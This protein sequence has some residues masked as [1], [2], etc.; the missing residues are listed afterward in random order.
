MANAKQTQTPVDPK[1]LGKAQET[2][3]SFMDFTKW[4]VVAVIGLLVFLAA[5][6]L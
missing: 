2:W 5:I 6:F 1:E 3:Q 4:G